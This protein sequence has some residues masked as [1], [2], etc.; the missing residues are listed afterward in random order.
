MRAGEA[1]VTIDEEMKY[2]LGKIRSVHLIGVGGAGMCGI[3]QVLKLNGYVVSGS[4]LIESNTTD[5]L[6]KLGINVFIGHHAAHVQQC[7]VVVKSTAVEEDNL[8]IKAAKAKGIPVIARAQMLAELMRFKHGIAVAGTH[9]KTTTT[10]LISSML[11]DAGLDPSFVIGGKLQSLGANAQVGNSR[12]FVAEADESDASFLY[13]QPVMAV[14]T[15]IDMDHMQ[16]Y[17]DDFLRL[18]DTFRQFL[19]QLPFYGLA[20]VCIDDPTVERLL[21]SLH[22]RYITYGFSDKAEIQATFWHQ[23]G[24][25]SQFMVKRKGR[26]PFPIHFNLPGKHNVQN[27]LAAIAIASELGISDEMI[28]T[29]IARFQGVGRRFQMLGHIPFKAGNALLIDDYGH[30]PKEISSTIDAI[31]GVWPDKRLIHVFQPH[32]YTR[33][34]ALF[35]DFTHSLSQADQVILLDVYSAGET[36]IEGVS[37]DSLAQKIRMI[38]KDKP[39]TVTSLESVASVLEQLI[40]E[41]DILLMQGAGSIG[42]AAVKLATTIPFHSS[43]IDKAVQ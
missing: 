16:T 9:G 18:Q 24:L 1:G 40:E 12:Y 41:G 5:Y 36:P 14:V 32:R 7:D 19:Q 23:D 29:S 25:S 8:E 37:S 2:P 26:E 33:T 35:D 17:G 20:V 22:C 38:D 27:A 42:Q 39:I 28:Q 13:L 30:H 15:N 11:N 4:D 34:K 21:P 3:A 6:K 43:V 10:S 31:R